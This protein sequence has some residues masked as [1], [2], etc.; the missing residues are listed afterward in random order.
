M[1]KDEGNGKSE[2]YALQSLFKLS[3]IVEAAMKVNALKIDGYS[4]GYGTILFFE[5]AASLNDL[6]GKIPAYES[7]FF[8]ACLLTD[9]R[10]F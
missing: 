9:Y 3:R 5:D 2:L 1:K 6:A 8:V 10:R 4:K 7:L